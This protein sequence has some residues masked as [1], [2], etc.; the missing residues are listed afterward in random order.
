MKKTVRLKH[1]LTH[2]VQEGQTYTIDRIPN[3]VKYVG[4]TLGT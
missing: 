4:L 2:W 3:T 1:L